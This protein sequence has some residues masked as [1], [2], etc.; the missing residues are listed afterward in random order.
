MTLL[1]TDWRF[2]LT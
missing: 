2:W 1:L